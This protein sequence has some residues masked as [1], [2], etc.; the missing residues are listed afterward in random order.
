M[1]MKI[2]FSWL[3]SSI[4]TCTFGTSMWCLHDFSPVFRIIT[5]QSNT[6]HHVNL[7]AKKQNYAWNLFTNFIIISVL[8]DSCVHLDNPWAI[9][10]ICGSILGVSCLLYDHTAPCNFIDQNIFFV[11][12]VYENHF[13]L[14]LFIDLHMD[15]WYMNSYSH[16]FRPISRSVRYAQQWTAPCEYSGQK[17][18]YH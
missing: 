18:N 16:V 15:L 17:T 13:V 12:N 9:H 10:R 6:L 5:L 2:N 7:S 11:L 4:R 1:W 8:I 3:Y 14:Y